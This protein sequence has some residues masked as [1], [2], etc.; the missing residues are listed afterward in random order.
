MVETD[1]A[2][3]RETS[4]CRFGCKRHNGSGAGAAWHDT[5]LVFTTYGRR[6]AKRKVGTFLHP[7]HV[8][9]VFYSLLD[10]AGLPRVR[11][12]TNDFFSEF[13]AGDRT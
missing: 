6:G 1:Y 8:L 4:M 13:G 3:L 10:E 2:L 9:R 5:G 7:R 12:L 11:F